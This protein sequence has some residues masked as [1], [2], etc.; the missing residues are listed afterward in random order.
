MK[1]KHGRIVHL[2]VPCFSGRFEIFLCNDWNF[3]IFYRW[4]EFGRNMRTIPHILKAAVSVLL[5]LSLIVSSM[6][7]GI[8]HEHQV[9]TPGAHMVEAHA[10]G[11]HSHG[12]HASHGGTQHGHQHL[13]FAGRAF[14]GDHHRNQTDGSVSIFKTSETSINA[15]QASHWSMV[16]FQISSPLPSTTRVTASSLDSYRNCDWIAALFGIERPAPPVPPPRPVC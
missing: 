3:L 5:G 9:S 15:H 10:H 4:K 6:V 12:K 13:H 1:S 14:N 7:V 16:T 2:R 11:D 8:Q